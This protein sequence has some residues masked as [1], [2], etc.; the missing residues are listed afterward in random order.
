MKPPKSDDTWYEKVSLPRFRHT[1]IRVSPHRLYPSELTRTPTSY[2]LILCYVGCAEVYP[3][4]KQP[5]PHGEFG[6]RHEARLP[7]SCR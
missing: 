5:V 2:E 1:G 7:R 6:N 4:Y 3:V